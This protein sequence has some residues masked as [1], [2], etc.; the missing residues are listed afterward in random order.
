MDFNQYK[1]KEQKR[2]EIAIKHLENGVDFVDINTAYID[3]GVDDWQRNTDRSLRNNR[4]RYCHR[5]EL[6]DSA[7]QQDQRCKR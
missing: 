5:R 7:K 6:P 3:E 1:E 2:L 4:R